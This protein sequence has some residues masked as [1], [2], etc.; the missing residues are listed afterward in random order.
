[1]DFTHTRRTIAVAAL[2]VA[3]GTLVVGCDPTGKGP[4]APAPVVPSS[5]AAPHTKDPATHAPA[6]AGTA[7]P[8]SAGSGKARHAP[9]KC[10]AV[11]LKATP[12]HQSAKRPQGTGTG[13]AVV[14]FTN[15]SAHPCTVRGFVTVAGAGNGSPDKNVPLTVHHTGTATTVLLAPGARAWTKLTFVPVS[16]EADGYCTS[17]STP[18]SYPTMV[19]GVP[20]AGHHQTAL[21]DGVLAECD[22]TVGVTPLSAVKPV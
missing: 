19:L 21:D 7:T 11:D 22:N 10:G 2:A 1:M 13:A 8:G 4:S 9:A 20:G 18:A 12:A 16:G 17:G 5:T 14:G 15:T 3:A 6:P